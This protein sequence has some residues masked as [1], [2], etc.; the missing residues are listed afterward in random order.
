MQKS[1]CLAGGIAFNCVANGKIF[2][3]T[4]FERVYVQPAAGDAGLSVGAAFAVNH[5][6]L[7][8]PRQFTD[9]ARVLGPQFSVKR[10]R[11]SVRDIRHGDDDV[12]IEELDE[13]RLLETTARHIASGKILGWFQGA[14]EWGPRALGKPQHSGRSAAARK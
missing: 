3:R 9:G 7:G 13:K 5:E 11:K 14:S 12:R 10:N 6:V 1:L 2:D 8:R 4:P